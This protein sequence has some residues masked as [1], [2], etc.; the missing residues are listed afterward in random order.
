MGGMTVNRKDLAVAVSLGIFL[1]WFLVVLAAVSWYAWQLAGSISWSAAAAP[2]TALPPVNK[3]SLDSA[4][5]YDITLSNEGRKGRKL[6]L[7]GVRVLA[8]RGA[9]AVS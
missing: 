4:K 9:S 5:R 3:I 1:G 7:R 8:A 6:V 2:A